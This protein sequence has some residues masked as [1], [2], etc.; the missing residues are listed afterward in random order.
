MLLTQITDYEQ[1]TE[2]HLRTEEG[3]PFDMDRCIT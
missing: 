3:H 1:Y 2:S